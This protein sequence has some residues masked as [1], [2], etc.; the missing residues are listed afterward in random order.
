MSP[1]R[2]SFSKPP[3]NH[4]LTK[5]EFIDSSAYLITIQ[6]NSFHEVENYKVVHI[7]Q[8]YSSEEDLIEAIGV[9]SLIC[10]MATVDTAPQQSSKCY[11]FSIA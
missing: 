6:H 4:H 9:K 8:Q 11:T 3:S 5:H 2:S 7:I 1:T 10:S